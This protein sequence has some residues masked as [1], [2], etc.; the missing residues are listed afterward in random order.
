MK[1]PA[2]LLSAIE[3]IALSRRFKRSLCGQD[4]FLSKL[5]KRSIR[6]LSTRCE[7]CENRNVVDVVLAS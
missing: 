5:K 1:R 3:S 2:A 4:W 7:R 6:K